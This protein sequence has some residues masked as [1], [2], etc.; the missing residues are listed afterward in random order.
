[1]RLGGTCLLPRT[2][3]GEEHDERAKEEQ[4][5]GCEDGPHAGRVVGVR[6]AAVF[7]DVVFDDLVANSLV[8]P[9]QHRGLSIRQR[10]RS[11]SP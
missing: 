9:R 3:A 1:M 5:H 6:A 4:D 11:Q 10:V 7:V 2:E 8:S